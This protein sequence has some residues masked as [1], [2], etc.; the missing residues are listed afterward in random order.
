[1]D[2]VVSSEHRDRASAL[3]RA[4]AALARTED[5]RSVGLHAGDDPTLVAALAAEPAIDAFLRQR[6]P[7]DPRATLRSLRSL[8]ALLEPRP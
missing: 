8:A 5:A 1:M 6:E 2:A 4:L 3:R 7:S